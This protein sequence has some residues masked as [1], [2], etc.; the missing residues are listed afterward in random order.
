MNPHEKREM[1]LITLQELM[2]APA[3][4]PDRYEGTQWRVQKDNTIMQC[5]GDYWISNERLFKDHFS[6]MSEKEWV[7]IGDFAYAL[8]N[9]RMRQEAKNWN[10]ALKRENLWRKKD[11]LHSM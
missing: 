1:K 11:E 4:I 6:H 3:E 9:A 2:T 10:E 5:D 8:K 7:D